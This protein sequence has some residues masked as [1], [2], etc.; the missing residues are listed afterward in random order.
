[1]IE[2]LRPYSEY[3]ETGL[4]WLPRIPRTWRI[5][6]NGSLFSQ[7]NQPGSE[8]LPI[9]E[10][11]LRSGVRVRSFEN[12]A[13]KQV[14]SDLTKYKRAEKHDL[15]YNTMRLWQGAVGAVPT[16]GL[17][18]PAYVVARPHP[19]V[20]TSF[21]SYLFRTDFYKHE[22][23][24]FSRGIVKDRNRLYWDQFKQMPSPA[25]PPEDQEAIVK[26]LDHANRRI[27]RF[28]RAKRKL[29]ALLNEQMQCITHRA[30]TRGLNQNVPLKNT[31]VPWLGRVPAHWEVLRLKNEVKC[32]D[33]QRIPLSSEVRGAMT[34]REYD[35]YGA[36]GVIDKVDEYIFD[37]ELLLIAEDGA[38][39]VLRN[40]PLAIIARGKFW[41]NNHAHILKP[42]RANIQYLA[43][44]IETIN[45]QPWITGAAQPKLTQD[46]LM[47][48]AICV[49][50]REEQ[51]AIVR[52]VS[53]AIAP[54][55]AAVSQ[56]QHEIALMREYQSRLVTDVVTGQLDVRDVVHVL[57]DDTPEEFQD[58]VDM[59]WDDS[60]EDNTVDVEDEG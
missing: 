39:L 49:A 21:Y 22:I 50:P 9:L 23:D 41:V 17:V 43:G 55:G 5:A 30:V 24:A 35:Y 47:S 31:E 40:L 28:I 57:P 52:S 42:I 13:R 4:P 26:F 11:S 56:A 37:D 6:R 7:R 19:G 59:N 53:E 46:R 15:A 33:R 3:V 16:A 45:Y 27:E 32:L 29:V 12:G 14:M 20:A 60:F 34:R 1:M 25:P 51:E 58:V 2:G 44:L 10:V 54:L 38:N 48:I 36:S 18:S 8:E